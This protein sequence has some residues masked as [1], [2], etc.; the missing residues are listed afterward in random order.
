MS[1][2]VHRD[3]DGHLIP[4]ELLRLLADGAAHPGPRLAGALGVSRAAVWKQIGA[5]RALGLDIETHPLRGYRIDDPP[6]LYEA[7]SLRVPGVA[8]EVLPEVDST[9]AEL[10]RHARAEGV[11]VP[12]V[13]LAEHQ[14]AG[15]G[16]R[17]RSWVAP[18]AR[19]VCLSMLWRSAHG[20]SALGGLSLALGVAVA[21]ALA[22]QGVRGVGLK[23]PNDVVHGDRKLAG[24][25]IEITGEAEG[26]SVVVAGVGVNHRM[27]ARAAVAIDQ[28]WADAMTLGVAGRNALARALVESLRDA[29]VR[30]E[31]EGLP[32]FAQR[33]SRLDALAGRVIGVTT[34]Q[35]LVEGIARGV[36]AD[37]ALRVETGQGMVR[38]FSGEVSVRA[39]T[40]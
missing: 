35:G 30:F 40:A 14:T 19:S 10:M 4:F 16:R 8:V 18:F 13:C 26:P 25:L 27:P 33:W 7:A 3:G 32:A 24:L 20:A 39:A 2:R 1:E 15:R 31:R 9:N 21:E 5:L 12:R 17:G 22:A 29:F 38:F 6:E 23:W 28:P 34:A 11:S 37:G 36:D